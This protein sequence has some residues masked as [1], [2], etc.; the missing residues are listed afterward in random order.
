[1]LKK[2]IA[3][4][5]VSVNVVLESGINKRIS[6]DGVTGGGSVYY[7][8][9][10]DV[11]SALERHYKFG[12]L[13]RVEVVEDAAQA[14]VNA[15]RPD[16]SEDGDV[17]SAKQSDFVGCTPLTRVEVSDP[18]A[19]KDYLAANFGVNRTKLKSLKAINEAAAAHGVE[20]EFN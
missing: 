10:A 9:D 15:G 17:L 11:Q 1:M 8:N 19:A 13:F 4:T 6:F 5:N 2:Y 20:F 18:A 16:E 12:R 3:K 14:D 7:T